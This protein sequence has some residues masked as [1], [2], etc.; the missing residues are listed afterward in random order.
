MTI[1]PIGTIHTPYSKLEE[2]PIQPKGAAGTIGT[3]LLDKAYA[4]GLADLD[5]FS[6]IYMLYHFHKASRTEL[7][8]TPFMDTVTR[9][10]FATRSPLRPSHIGMSVTEIISVEGNVV[11]VKGIDI[12]DGTP[13]LDIKPYIPQFDS[14]S[15]VR[16]G[17]MDRSDEEVADASSDSRFV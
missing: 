10:V 8:V 11:T 5:G 16:T 7:T 4:Q 15:D 1:E 14:V 13:L 17:W 3:L 12:L 2:M 6:H 9:G